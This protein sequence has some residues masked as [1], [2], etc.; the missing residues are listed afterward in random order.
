MSLIKFVLI[1]GTLREHNAEHPSMDIIAEESR[2]FPW[3]IGDSQSSYDKSRS[4]SSSRWSIE[5]NAVS[6]R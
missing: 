3:P 4:R 2:V 1:S 6:G 5:L